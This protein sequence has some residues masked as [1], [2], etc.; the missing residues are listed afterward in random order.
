VKGKLI[1]HALYVQRESE[2]CWRNHCCRGKAVSITHRECVC[3]LIYP[4]C[5]VLPPC[6]I[7][8]CNLSGS[9][10]LIHI[11][12]KRNDVRKIVIGHQM[13]VFPLHHLSGTFLILRGIQRYAITNLYMQ[14]RKVG[15]RGGAVVKAL[16]YKPAGRGFDFRWCHWNF[17]VT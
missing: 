3:G 15:A 12:H 1:R 16:R 10:T 11:D 8:V 2:A 17:S 14:C 13:C 4:V 6:Y 5:K 9:I 7:G